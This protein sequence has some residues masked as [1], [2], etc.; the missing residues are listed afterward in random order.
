M[1][2]ITCTGCGAEVEPLDVFPRN[3][4]LS[5]HAKAFD[6]QNSIRPQTADDVV[7]MGGGR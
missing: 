1:E 3:R 4:C 5:C 2:T 6:L 7:R